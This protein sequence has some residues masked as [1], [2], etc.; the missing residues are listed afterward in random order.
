[1]QC[2]VAVTEY[3]QAPSSHESHVTSKQLPDF[4]PCVNGHDRQAICGVEDRKS[5]T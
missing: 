2:V 5:S 3:A 1:M 4:V